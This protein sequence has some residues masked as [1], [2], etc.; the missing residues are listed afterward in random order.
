MSDAEYDTIAG[1]V[2]GQLGRLPRRGEV[3]TLDGIEFTV[4]KADRRRVF[5]VRAR[6]P[7]ARPAAAE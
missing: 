4:L 6:F 3:I 2:I 7:R 5:T 1:L